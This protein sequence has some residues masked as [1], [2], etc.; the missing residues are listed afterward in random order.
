MS[1]PQVNC[2][3][4]VINERQDHD[5]KSLSMFD[6]SDFGNDEKDMREKCFSCL[7]DE[8]IERIKNGVG[9]CFSHGPQILYLQI[10]KK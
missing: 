9:G 8:K 10:E 7:V 2:H 1:D 6:T 5:S 4:L 3:S